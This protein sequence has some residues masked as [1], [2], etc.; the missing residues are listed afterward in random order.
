MKTSLNT[1]EFAIYTLWL[2]VIS[3]TGSV[4]AALLSLLLIVSS[5]KQVEAATFNSNSVTIGGT[6]VTGTYYTD[7][8]GTPK[9]ST[10]T[11]LGSFDRGSGRLTFVANSSTS[12]SN[13]SEDVSKVELFYRV[14]AAT[15]TVTTTTPNFIAASLGVTSSSQ[16][17]SNKTWQSSTPPIVDILGATTNSGNYIVEFYFSGTSTVKNNSS[18]FQETPF[19]TYKATFTVTGSVPLTWTGNAGNSSWNSAANWADSNNRNGI[20]T[21]TTDVTIPNGLQTPYPL[22]S[23]AEIDYVR[24]LTITGPR[25]TSSFDGGSLTTVGGELRVYGNFSDPN[26]GFAAAQGLFTLAGVDQAFDSDIF[27]RVSIQGGGTKSLSSNTSLGS[28]AGF[29]TIKRSLTFENGGGVIKTRTDNANRYGVSLNN[30]VGISG[31]NETSYVLGVLNTGYTF[32][33][34]DL[35]STFGNIGISLTAS[36]SPDG[37]LVT[38]Y[39][40]LAYTGTAIKT[41]SVTRSFYFVPTNTPASFSLAFTYLTT[42]LNGNA[43]ANLSF[44]SSP[45]TTNTFTSIGRTSVAANTVTLTNITSNLFSTFTVAESAVPLPVTLISFMATPTAQGAALLRWA[46][47]TESNNRGFGIERQ[48]GANEAW[49]SVGFVAAGATTGSTYEFTDKSLVNAPASAQAYYR[50]R[51]E[52]LNGKVTYSPVAAI[53]R[54]AAV[55]ATEL[56]LSPVPVSGTDNLSVGLAEAGQA[57]IMVAVTNT[58]GQRLMSFTTQASTDGALSLPVTSLA[59]GVYIVTVQVPG[60]AARHARFVKL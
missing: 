46:T 15:T 51:Q 26:A 13:G 4:F 48:L 17:G 10:L 33:P 52:D 7:L 56:T 2:R 45:S 22:I 20:P 30:G 11:T 3:K 24:N 50:L 19:K 47:A 31:E 53:N 35:T 21:S 43:A 29:M 49:Q 34:S 28:T 32:S 58:Q 39:T 60:Q 55:A 16:G 41:A 1:H 37:V 44:F 54:T 36:S 5:A 59:A 6:G 18:I 12:S 25:T 42:E 8:S 38:R 27:Y 23:G 57:G 14:Y 40:G 9:F